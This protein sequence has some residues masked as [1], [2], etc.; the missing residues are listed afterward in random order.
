MGVG[1]DDRAASRIANGR[2][3]L[4]LAELMLEE[5]F[6][7]I[8]SWSRQEDF[9]DRCRVAKEEKAKRTVWAMGEG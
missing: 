9:E 7:S 1:A 6:G 8:E 4:V 2:V 3:W 5:A